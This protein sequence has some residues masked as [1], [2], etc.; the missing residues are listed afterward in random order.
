MMEKLKFLLLGVFITISA[1]LLIN[2]ASSSSLSNNYQISVG[3]SSDNALVAI[4]NTKTGEFYT[5]LNGAS[6]WNGKIEDLKKS[7]FK[8][9]K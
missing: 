5:F 2:S 4:I 9:A 7:W 6:N 3:G 8:Q 1:I